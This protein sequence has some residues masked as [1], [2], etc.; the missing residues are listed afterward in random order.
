MLVEADDLAT[1]MDIGRFSNRQEDNANMIL[2]GVQG[3]I[4]A[5]L[6]RPIEPIEF[7]EMYG[8]PEDYLMISSTSYFY[9]RTRDTMVDPIERIVQPPYVLHLRNSP[10]VSVEQIRVRSLNREEWRILNSGLQYSHSRWGIDMFTVVG[11]DEV[12]VTYTAGLTDEATPYLKLLILRVASREMQN[13]TDDVV[14]LKDLG[15]REVALREIGLNDS[16]KMTLRRWRRR[17]I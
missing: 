4:E 6:R 2:A 9:D 7:V 16:D 5:F 11:L 12:E 10:V 1:Y 14:G 8:V 15:T 3:E 17:Q 13:L